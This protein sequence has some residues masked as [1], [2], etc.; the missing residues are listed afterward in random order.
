MRAADGRSARLRIAQVAPLYVRVPP[1]RYGGTER[2]V[3][4]LTTE[5]VRRGH[6]VT[7]FAAGGSQTPARLCAVAPQPLWEINPSERLPYEI[8]QIV[9]VASQSETFD[10]IHWH[11]DFL[12]WLMSTRLRAPWVTTLHGRLNAPSVR[13]LFAS[14]PDEPV[15]SISDAQRLP[16]HD[17]AVNWVATVHNGLDMASRYAL[18]PGDGGYLAFVGRSSSDKGLATA[19]RVAVRSGWPIKIGARVGPQGAAYHESQVVPLLQH[20]LVEWYGEVTDKEKASLLEGAAALLMPIEWDEPFGLSFIEALAAGTPI[21]TRPKGALPELMR[22]G[23]HG[24]F[25]DT[26]DEMVAACGRLHEIDRTA[27]RRW[28]LE[29]FSTARMVDDYEAVYRRLISQWTEKGAAQASRSLP[30]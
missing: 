29:R 5:L 14:H 17:L 4:E 21:I 22:H 16:L 27:C 13:L 7:L 1:A 23:V 15:V 26:E 30:A 6:D 11:L 12:H 20:P 3:H 19:I 10:V 28:A 25:A 9:E 24:F 8:E 2:V 18:G